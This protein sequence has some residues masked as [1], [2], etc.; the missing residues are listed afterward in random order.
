MYT[1]LAGSA[2]N[3]DSKHEYSFVYY[4]GVFI[5]YTDINKT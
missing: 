3:T 2:I 1:V 4:I 5:L